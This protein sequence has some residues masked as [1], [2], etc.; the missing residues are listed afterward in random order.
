MSRS[1]NGSPLFTLDRR[2]AL[3]G[4]A[5][6]AIAGL[7]GAGPFITRA[8][9]ADAPKR[10]GT[11]IMARNSDIVSFEPVVPTDNMS[12]W[13]KLL[14][15]QMLARPSPSGDGVEPDLAERWD[16]SPD[17]RTYTFHIRQNAAFSDGSPV[18]AEDVAFS[19][20]R[21]LHGA[22]SPWGATYPKLTLETPDAR[23]VVFKLG[24]DYAPFLSAVSL[25]GA[26]IVPKDYFSKAGAKAFGEKPIGSGP[27]RMLEWKKGDSITFD[28]N[29]H[30]WNPEKPYLDRVV[31]SIIEDDNVRM[32]KVQ[33]GEIDIA[34]FVPF[35][36]IDKLKRASGVEVQ[37]S[38][39]ERVDW[40][41]FNDKLPLFQ[42]VKIR[43]AMNYAVNKEAIVKAVLFGHGEVP[44]SFLPKMYMTD[45]DQK[46]YAYDLA[47]AKQLMAQSSQP[48]GFAVTLKTNAGDVIGGQV[49][50][51]V[52]QMLLP[53][54]IKMTIEPVEPA[55]QEQQ[56]QNGDYQMAQAY[57]TSDILDP[58][59]LVAYAAQS[60]GGSNA[61]YSNYKN[62]KVD[63]LARQALTEADEGKRR[64]LYKELQQTVFEDAA[65]LWLY[66]TP[67][68]TAVRTNVHGFRVLPT[69]N[70]WLEDVWKS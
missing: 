39:Y 62:P 33:S 34:T 10:G 43:Q 41:Q 8:R 64:A 46:P 69:G 37:V 9:A 15:F 35:N 5:A 13:A 21:V 25:H 17:K 57:M 59:E 29:P 45:L 61:A 54:G 18:T 66:W 26:C 58:S 32:L 1:V 23:T 30:F 20:D 49:A 38:P 51:I 19:F 31:L 56:V 2:T 12:I 42:D 50:Q 63:A 70:Y 52:Q 28:R 36:Q 22:D 55:T 14:I 11:L 7:S 4:S 53:L 27:F 47:K 24:E 60:D 3:L 40:L 16:I 68:V 48:N 65:M 6:V 44:T 67:A